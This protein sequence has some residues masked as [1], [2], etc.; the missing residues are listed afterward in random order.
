MA[1]HRVP[2]AGVAVI[3]DGEQVTAWG[4]GA[5]GGDRSTPVRADTVFQSCSVSKH[6]TT[7]GVLRLVQ[8]GVLDL[9]TDVHTYL[10]DWR[11][12]DGT[13]TVTVR[14]L[15]SHTAGLTSGITSS[16]YLEHP[17]DGGIPPLR[18]MIDGILRDRPVGTGFRYSNAHFAVLQ[19]IVAD[20]TGRSF[21]EAMRTL[22]LD[23]LGMADSGYEHDFPE[24]RPDRAACGHLAD[25]TPYAGGWPLVPDIA[26]SGLW[27]TPKDVSSVEIAILRALTGSDNGFL[28]AEL[29]R[30]MVTPHEGMYGLGTTTTRG[31]D[32]H[33]FGHPGD[34]HCYQGFTAVDLR[35][36][37]GLVV[38]ANIG[39][40]APFLGDVVDRLGLDI[41]FNVR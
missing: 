27:S 40:E 22:V 8:H 41:N 11:L 5:T 34:R 23:P 3:T 25:G 12:P 1:R 2:G 36:G 4:Q 7:V 29:A 33:W 20:V 19:Q 31:P 38:L 18:P 21:A 30:Q 39:G 32:R 14:H 13:G 28:A 10:T 35:S 6:V 16:G 17:R 26:S 24:T 37:T 9:D 15:L